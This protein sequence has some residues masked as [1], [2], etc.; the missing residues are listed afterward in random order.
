MSDGPGFHFVGGGVT[1]AGA[2]LL[3]VLRPG[4][5]ARRDRETVGSVGI[6]LVLPG[7]CR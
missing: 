7:A 5:L 2:G 3:A 1:R 4:R 6:A